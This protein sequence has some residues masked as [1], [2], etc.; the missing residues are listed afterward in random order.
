MEKRTKKGKMGNIE[1]V[2]K[3]GVCVVAWGGGEHCRR[4][5][6]GAGWWLVPDEGA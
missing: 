2:V 5:S 6:E 1:M 3:V 4:A